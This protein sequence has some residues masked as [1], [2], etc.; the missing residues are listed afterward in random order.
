MN[1]LGIPPAESSNFAKSKLQITQ[2]AVAQGIHETVAL[3]RQDELVNNR[4][5]KA[6]WGTGELVLLQFFLDKFMQR[7]KSCLRT[8]EKKSISMVAVG[9]C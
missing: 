8:I 7:R 6:Y 4:T 9:E 3:D 2:L 1:E 5:T